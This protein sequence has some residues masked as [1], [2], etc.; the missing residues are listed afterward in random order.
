MEEFQDDEILSSAFHRQRGKLIWGMRHEAAA[1]V[2]H[3]EGISAPDPSAYGEFRPGKD[4]TTT[5]HW[6]GRLIVKFKFQVS[7]TP[8]RGMDLMVDR[9]YL[10]DSSAEMF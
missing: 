7:P 10:A 9:I 8:G 1:A 2:I 4:G 3:L 5:F 6:R